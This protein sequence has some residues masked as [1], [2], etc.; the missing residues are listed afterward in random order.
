MMKGNENLEKE[1]KMIQTQLES[2]QGEKRKKLIKRLDTVNA[3]R[4]SDNKPEWMVMSVLP[5]I[6]PD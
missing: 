6:P 4:N 2:A 1:H 3:F 5:V